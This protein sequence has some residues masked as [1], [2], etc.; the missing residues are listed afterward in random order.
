MIRC[1]R[2]HHHG[3]GK[4]GGDGSRHGRDIMDCRQHG[5][6]R[7]R[8]GQRGFAPVNR[9]GKST[10]QTSIYAGGT[11]PLCKNHCSLSEPGCPKGEALAQSFSPQK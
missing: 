2:I 6:G 8:G 3:K 5:E 7:G 10:E 1:H 4:H 11:C 9:D